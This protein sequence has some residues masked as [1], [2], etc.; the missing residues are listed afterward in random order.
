MIIVWSKLI[1]ALLLLLVPIG[2]FHGR[3]TRFRAIQRDWDQHWPQ[4]LTLGSHWIDLSRAIV[5]AWALMESLSTTPGADGIMRY[6]AIFATGAVLILSMI[7]QTFVCKERDS[8]HAPFMFVTGLVLGAFPLA[9]AAFAVVLA[10]TITAGCRTPGA[11]FPLLAVA[12]GGAGYFFEGAAAIVPIA[13][14]CCAVLVPWI[15]PM[16]FRR[17]LM[18]TYRAARRS[19]ADPG[20]T[21]AA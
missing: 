10:S 6:G 7:L 13:L 19:Q 3:K 2:L 1:P 21:R 17:D 15:L 8:A 12:L 5:G 9:P 18:L 4:I 20:A 16:M 14:G 11:Y